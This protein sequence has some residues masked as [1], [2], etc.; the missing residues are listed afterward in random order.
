MNIFQNKKL[1]VSVHIPKDTGGFRSLLD[2]Y[3][4]KIKIKIALTDE[5]RRF[6]LRVFEIFVQNVQSSSPF[7][8]KLRDACASITQLLKDMYSF[9]QTLQVS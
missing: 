2:I 7:R 8:G 4:C 1:T 5:N 3:T 6:S 9:A